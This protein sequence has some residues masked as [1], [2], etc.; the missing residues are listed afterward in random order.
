MNMAASVIKHVSKIRV[1]SVLN[2]DTKQFGKQFLL[3]SQD[4]TCWNSDQG[5]PQFIHLEFD[6]AVKV[7]EVHIQFQ[8][9]F[10][11]KECW[12]ECKDCGSSGD[13]RSLVK[14]TDI[15]P[16]DVN[17]VQRFPMECP[18]P[19]TAL[20]IIFNT[21]TDFF[22]RIIIYKLDILGQTT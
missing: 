3:D 16:E 15:Y 5:C 7:S 17:S 13:K 10:V 2:R 4:E 21:S 6:A 14:V 12:V 9:G 22:G 8:G 1:S 18:E 20:R 11:G 19:T